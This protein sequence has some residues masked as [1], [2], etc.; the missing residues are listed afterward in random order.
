M[1]IVGWR[2]F[3]FFQLHQTRPCGHRIGSLKWRQL[4]LHWCCLMH[5]LIGEDPSTLLFRKNPK[6]Y[7]ADQFQHK[8]SFGINRVEWVLSMVQNNISC[9]FDTTDM[10]SSWCLYLSTRPAMITNRH[11][12]TWLCLAPDIIAIGGQPPTYSMGLWAVPQSVPDCFCCIWARYTI[13]RA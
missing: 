7:W 1:T 13:R 11:S 10:P 9:T 2:L 8:L 3:V 6:S 5:S 4:H 12:P